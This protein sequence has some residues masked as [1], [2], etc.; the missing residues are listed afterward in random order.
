MSR[1]RLNKGETKQLHRLGEKKHMIIKGK[2]IKTTRKRH[3]VMKEKSLALPFLVNQPN[4]N[5]NF[6][7]KSF[8]F[9]SFFTLFFC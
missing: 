4:A 9:H 7:I 1:A 3:A 2:K 6:E 5:G 8:F